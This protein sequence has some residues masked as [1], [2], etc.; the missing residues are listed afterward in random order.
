MNSLPFVN[1]LLNGAAFYPC[2]SIH[3]LIWSNP[4]FGPASAAPLNHKR[5][6]SLSDDLRVELLDDLSIGCNATGGFNGD[7]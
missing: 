1:R 4:V 7:F 6:K 5:L 2:P 3:F